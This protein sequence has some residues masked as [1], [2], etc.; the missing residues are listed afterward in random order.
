M[1]YAVVLGILLALF[2]TH[3]AL[4]QPLINEVMPNPS[5]GSYDEWVEIWNLQNETLNLSEWMIVD[6]TTDN[7]PINCSSNCITNATYF[8][9]LGNRGNI[10]KITNES[11]LYFFIINSDIGSGLNNGADIVRFFNS[12]HNATMNY[13]YTNESYSWALIDGNWTL[14]S[15]PTPGSANN[16]TTGGNATSQNVALEI[17][18]SSSIL[19]NTTY[20]GI[21]NITI[22]NKSNCSITDN[23]TLYYNITTNSSIIKEENVTAE[24]GCNGT[25]GNWTPNATGEYLVCGQIFNTTANNTNTSTSDDSACMNITVVG[26]LVQTCDLNISIAAPDILDLNVSSRLDYNITVNDRACNVTAHT[27]NITYRIDD[28]FGNS[29]SICSHTSS[30]NMTCTDVKLD[31]T[32]SS[33]PSMSGSE[34]FVIKANISATGCTDTNTTNNYIE[35]MFVI[36]SNTSAQCQNITVVSTTSSGGGGSCPTT[37]TSLTEGEDSNFY[38]TSAPTEMRPG[39]AFDVVVHLKNNASISRTF[40][41]YSYVFDGGKLLSEGQNSS[42]ASQARDNMWDKGWEANK[43]NITILANESASVALVNRIKANTTAAIYK[44]RVR[45]E[46]VRDMTRQIVVTNATLS[47]CPTCNCTSVESVNE[48]APAN[49]TTNTSFNTTRRVISHEDPLETIKNVVG[50]AVTGFATG[51]QELITLVAERI[52]KPDPML[53]IRI[54][55]MSWD[56][57]IWAIEQ[58]IRS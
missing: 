5:T 35:K 21:F 51:T 46:N 4:A 9:I 40:S 12:T 47:A 2:I 57:F 3:A 25:A 42:S 37:T 20:D 23:V 11:I 58:M 8:L 33:W 32:C 49:E 36:K 31:P 14:C 43:R 55:A 26:E 7:D 34:A 52:P 56:G 15:T 30:R 18:L 28:L 38:F 10:S 53:G 13:S 41:V 19:V 39:Q 17:N 16:C 24:I 44:L 29:I 6:N 1:R 22:A 54:V 48:T 50:S 45:I 27:V